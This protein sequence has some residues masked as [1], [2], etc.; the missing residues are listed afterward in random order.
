ME[1]YSEESSFTLTVS[2]LDMF[3][4]YDSVKIK[5]QNWAGGHPEEQQRLH[6]LKNELYRGVLEYKYHNVGADKE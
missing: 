3:L 4:L 6:L 1:D 2:P 5:I